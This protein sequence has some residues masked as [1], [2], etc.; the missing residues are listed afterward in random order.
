[1]PQDTQL[2]FFVIDLCSVGAFQIGQNEI[3]VIKL[4]LKV[5]P[6]DPL[7]I[8]LDRIPLFSPD[9]DRCR[10]IIEYATT[11]GPVENS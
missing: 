7:V 10:H 6:A 8:E 5:K 1:M 11:I 2:N 3:F 9:G 4:N